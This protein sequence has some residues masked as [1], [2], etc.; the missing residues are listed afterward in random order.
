[1]RIEWDLRAACTKKNEETRELEYTLTKS[2]P[3]IMGHIMVIHEAEQLTSPLAYES[4]F[5]GYELAESLPHPRP[6]SSDS[7]PCNKET[8]MGPSS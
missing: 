1:M 6:V 4:Y 3:H 5:S 7:L 8:I 2:T